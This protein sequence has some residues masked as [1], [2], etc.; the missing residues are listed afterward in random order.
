MIKIVQQIDD[1][2]L[3][4]LNFSHTIKAL[5]ADIISN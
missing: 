2:F 4:I 5:L 1:I 3:K